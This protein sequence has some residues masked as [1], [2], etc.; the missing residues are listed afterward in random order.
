MKRMGR[1]PGGVIAGACGTTALHMLTYLDMT[2]RGRPASP[3]PAQAAEKMAE[4]LGIELAADGDDDTKANRSEGLGALLGYGAGLGAGLLY[5]VVGDRMERWP[6]AAQ[7]SALALGAMLAGNVPA[8]GMGI[9]DP[10]QWSGTDWLADV[11]PHAVYGLVTAAAYQ[12]IR[13]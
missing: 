12:S 13:H 1:I 9:T 8:A 6:L 4:G 2:A 10:R 7:A 3:L 5:S 11:V